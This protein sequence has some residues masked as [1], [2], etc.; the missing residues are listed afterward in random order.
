MQTQTVEITLRFK[1][2]LDTGMNYEVFADE[3]ASL[4]VEHIVDCVGVDVMYVEEEEE[5][6]IGFVWSQ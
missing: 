5:E 2:I 3:F 6:D 4:C 1:M